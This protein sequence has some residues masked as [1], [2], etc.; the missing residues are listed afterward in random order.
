MRNLPLH[1]LKEYGEGNV[2]NLWK[3]EKCEKKMVEF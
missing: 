3:W 2:R 1:V